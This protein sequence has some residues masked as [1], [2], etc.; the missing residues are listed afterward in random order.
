MVAEQR[1]GVAPHERGRCRLQ[2]LL[3]DLGQS[4]HH[5]APRPVK[6]LVEILTIS[7][8]SAM[9]LKVLQRGAGI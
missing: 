4:R 1:L 5:S 2:L 3:P 6:M 9:F 8:Q 7:A